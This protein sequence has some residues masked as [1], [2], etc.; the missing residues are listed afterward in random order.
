MKLSSLIVAV[1]SSLVLM[2]PLAEAKAPPADWDGLT[3]V[4]SKRF[5]LVYLQPGVNFSGY[6]KVIVDPTEVA[7]H[8]DWRRNYNSGTRDLGGKV[9]DRDVEDAVRRGI[10][11]ATN[12]FAKA[13]EK[14]GYPVVTESGPDVLRVRTGVVNISVTAPDVRSSARSYN[15]ADTAG[16]ATLVIEVRDS[17]TNALLGRAVD[18]RIAGDNTVGWRSS[19]SNRGDFEALVNDWARDAVKGFTALKAEAAAKP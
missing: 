10:P 3:R 17:L 8:K 16:Q 11:A 9:S 2:A 19:V 15:F 5:N 18:Q 6:T 7:F 13:W 14:G 1:A 4:P 12:I